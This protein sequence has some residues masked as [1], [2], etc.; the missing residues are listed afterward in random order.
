MSLHGA[1]G[2]PKSGDVVF[3]QR[4]PLARP[5]KEKPAQPRLSRVSGPAGT[6]SD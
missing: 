4:M 6:A 5:D 3:F 2:I 1:P